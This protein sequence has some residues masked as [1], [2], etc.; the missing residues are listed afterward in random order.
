MF[1]V[2]TVPVFVSVP[3][4]PSDNVTVYVYDVC[5]SSAGLVR[6]VLP[7]LPV[8]FAFPLVAS[9]HVNVSPSWSEPV[10]V[11][12]YFLSLFASADTLHVPIF[13]ELFPVVAVP[14]TPFV[15]AIP[16][17]TSIL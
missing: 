5:A 13:G 3:P 14:S 8:T 2:F 17:V 9:V 1:F 7:P 11:T 10:T 12:V 6:V 4:F 16:S 15:S